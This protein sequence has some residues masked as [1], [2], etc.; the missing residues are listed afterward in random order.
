MKSVLETIDTAAFQA[1]AVFAWILV[2]LVWILQFS[3]PVI[4]CTVIP[5][6]A[7]AYYL[8]NRISRTRL[9]IPAALAAAALLFTV[10]RLLS[11]S[12]TFFTFPTTILGST[13][14]YILAEAVF[15]TPVLF[16]IVFL[17]RF[18]TMRNTLFLFFETVIMTVGLSIPLWGHRMGAI[19]RPV[20]LIDRTW[21]YG[22]DPRTVFFALGLAVCLILYF[23]ISNRKQGRKSVIDAV[24]FTLILVIL[25]SII[26][27]SRIQREISRV[28]TRGEGKGKGKNSQKLPASPSPSQGSRGS[29][30]N[31]SP[32]PSQSGEDRR[33]ES[34]KDDDD[35]TKM[36]NSTSSGSDIPVAVVE[37]QEDYSPPDG[38]YYF[39]QTAFSQYNGMRLVQDTSGSADRDL[40]D[41]FPT[42]EARIQL[43]K[44]EYEGAGQKGSSHRYLQTT[45]AMI[46]SHTR[47]F[48]MANMV[49][50]KPLKNVDPGR[51]DRVYQAGS[52]VRTKPYEKILTKPVGNTKWSRA[53]GAHYT[54]ATSDPR[55]RE[56]CGEIIS[57]IRPDLR[58]NPIARAIAIKLW[59]DRNCVYNDTCSHADA[60]DPT[61]SFLFGDR[62]GYC[63]YLA[64]S[65]CYLMRTA[66]IPT[67][68]CGGYS[69]NERFRGGGSTILILGKYSHLW[70]EIYIEGCGWV[71]ID[72]S[73]EKTMVPPVESPD[74]SLQSMMGDM[75]RKN[76][77]PESEKVPPPK[78]PMDFRPLLRALAFCSLAGILVLYAVKI[79]RR[80]RPLFCGA[81]EFPRAAYIAALDMLSEGG[82]ARW[83]GE[84]REAFAERLSAL[85]PS[86]I[87]L[88]GF[89]LRA[90]FLPPD[91][92]EIPGPGASE[93]YSA[94]KKEISDAIPLARKMAGLVNPFSWLF[95]R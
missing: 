28:A 47:P 9:S 25:F 15:W 41:D 90:W 42:R 69:V 19:N 64:H 22:I 76:T 44:G 73:P 32:S 2:S 3:H 81:G 92:V 88:T 51:F 50:I 31:A 48:G 24:V 23:V 62:T 21:F 17:C 72:I 58:S 66:G 4:L 63:V 75:V 46:R 20:A 78:L 89:H 12:L 82:H 80:V 18:L 95:S 34:E 68:L 45:V 53:M 59:L 91:R 36:Q 33:P 55:Y 86:F 85:S 70:P 26:P 61:A 30:G 77:T 5:L 43:E 52:Y 79:Y 37:L 29:Q 39:R 1:C 54:G 16:T 11:S 6:V 71:I 60:E 7:L 65:A 40:F 56:L 35:Q 49:M 94:T 8:G 57:H 10:A 87:K 27:F 14:V 93:V 83:H 38:H 67:R 13:G 84:T 74:K